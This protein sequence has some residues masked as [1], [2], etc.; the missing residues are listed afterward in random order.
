MLRSDNAEAVSCVVSGRTVSE[1]LRLAKPDHNLEKR[2]GPAGLGDDSGCQVGSG[3]GKR[4]LQ[5]KQDMQCPLNVLPGA[6]VGSA[7][8]PGIGIDS[9]REGLMDPDASSHGSTQVLRGA[10]IRTRADWPPAGVFRNDNPEWLIC[11]ARH[12]PPQ[13]G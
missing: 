8:S 6:A 9:P 11:D 5:N 4:C 13:N 1:H 7:P 2:A 10:R 3:P 12:Q